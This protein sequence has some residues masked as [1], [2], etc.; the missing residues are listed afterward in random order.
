MTFLSLLLNRYR[1]F[2]DSVRIYTD[3][4][5]RCYFLF[6]SKFN[7]FQLYIKKFYN[8]RHRM[9]HKFSWRIELPGGQSTNWRTIIPKKFS[10]ESEFEG[11]EDLITKLPQDR[12]NRDSWRVQI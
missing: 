7:F 8:M 2:Y 5:N 9:W 1:T 6:A 12:G 4:A 10:R 11:Q 3:Y